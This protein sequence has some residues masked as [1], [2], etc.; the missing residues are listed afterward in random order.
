MRTNILQAKRDSAKDR[1]PNVSYRVVEFKNGG[2]GTLQE[3]DGIDQSSATDG[4]KILYGS[5]SR[6]VA[7]FRN[8]MLVMA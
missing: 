6:T 5:I 8:G 3:F 1:R 7:T 4:M 2:V